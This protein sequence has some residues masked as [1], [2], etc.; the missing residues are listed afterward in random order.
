VAEDAVDQSAGARLD[1][2]SQPSWLL[3]HGVHLDRPLAGTLAHNPRS[4]MNNGVG[5]GRPARWDSVVLGTDGIGADMLEEFRL[6]FACHRADDV[7][8]VPSA[9]WSWLEAGASLVPGVRQDRVT[10]SYD[11]MDPWHLAYTPGVRPITVEVAGSAVLADG[12]PTRVDPVEI[13]ARAAEQARRLW[14]AM[15]EL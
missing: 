13:R 11:T 2:V 12:R 14:A 1:G 15:E 6:A 10:W 4:N 7:T 9:A 3:A 5:Y 8:A